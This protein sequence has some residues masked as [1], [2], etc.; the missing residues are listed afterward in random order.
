MIS[1]L[2]V[3]SVSEPVS[4]TAAPTAALTGDDWCFPGDAALCQH[5]KGRGQVVMMLKDLQLGDKVLL[6]KGNNTYESMYSISTNY[7]KLSLCEF[8]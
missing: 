6:T 2:F 1:E 7:M 4:P 8:M 5:V 3:L